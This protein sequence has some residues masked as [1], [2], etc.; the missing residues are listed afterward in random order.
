MSEHD[1]D[2]PGSTYE[3]N[4]KENLIESDMKEFDK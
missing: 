4:T 2:Q 3:K 1:P